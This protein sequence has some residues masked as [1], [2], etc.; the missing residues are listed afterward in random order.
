MLKRLIIGFV[1]IFI[2]GALYY[3]VFENKSVSK[4]PTVSNNT[5]PIVNNEAAI[6][7]KA[8]ANKQDISLEPVTVQAVLSKTFLTQ[9]QILL[10]QL[11]EVEH[12][13]SNGLCPTNEKDPKQAMFKQEAL[14][15]NRRNL[16]PILH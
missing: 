15:V 1:L 5:M 10:S 7:S 6:S 12:C 8:D 11:I 13:E 4:V 16:K 2:A 3:Q 9:R 14:L